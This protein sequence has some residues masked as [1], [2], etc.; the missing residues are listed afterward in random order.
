M[1]KSAYRGL[2]RVMIIFFNVIYTLILLFYGKRQV[3]IQKTSILLL[4]SLFVL[5]ACEGSKISAFPQEK[6][7]REILLKEGKYTNITVDELRT[8]LEEK[9]FIFI[10]VHIPFEGDI[11]GTDLSIPFDEIAENLDKLPQ[12]KDAQIV[13]YCRSGRMSSIAAETMVKLGYSNIWNLE[14]GMIAWE[15]EGLPL[16]GR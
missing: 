10:N 16:I 14:G 11:A 1:G 3:M 15:K 8:M 9:D 5:S 7:G 13:L 6:A 4:L 12:N 2:S